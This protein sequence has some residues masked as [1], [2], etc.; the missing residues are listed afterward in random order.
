M[1]K[2]QRQTKQRERYSMFLIR[3]INI[4]KINTTKCNLQIHCYP[5]QITNGI[6]TKLEKQQQKSH[7]SYRNKQTNKKILNS[8][9]ILGKKNGP[10]ESIFPD[11]G[12]C[13]KTTVIKKVWYWIKNRNIDQ[14]SK[15]EITEIN[16]HT[17]GFLI[18]NQG[19]K[20][21]K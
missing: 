19:G 5:Y 11:F 16:P 3:R 8:Q 18:F 2:D 13:Y 1:T 7:N 14:W 6:F 21:I 20:N 10:G 12:S 15:I 4:V 9:A 17:N